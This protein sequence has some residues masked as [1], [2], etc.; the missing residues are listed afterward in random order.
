M[1]RRLAHVMLALLWLAAMLGGGRPV[2]AAAPPCGVSPI[3]AGCAV[4]PEDNIW[5]VPVDALPVHARSNAYGASIGADEPVHPDFGSGLWE[6][7]PIG[8]P[9][10]VVP[11]NQPKVEVSFYY[12]DESDLGPYPI[13]P[14]AP[15]EGGA[16]SDGDRHILVL[17]R[18]HCI[19]YEVYDAWPREDGSWECGSGAIY[20]LR[21]NA[22]RPDTW[23]SADAAGLP[24]LPGLVRYDEVAAG[25]ITHAIRVT[26]PRTQRAYVWP[27]RHYASSSTDPNLP[28]MGQRFRLKAGFDISGYSAE[29][30]VILRAMKKYGVILADNGAPWYISGAPDER[31]DND[32][33]HA[34]HNVS[35]SDFEAVDCSSLMLDPDSAQAACQASGERLYLPLA[36]G[37]NLVSLSLAP[38][39]TDPAAALSSIAGRYAAAYAYD[40]ANAADPWKLY[41]PGAPAYANDLTRL[42]ERMGWWV[43]AAAPVTLTLRGEAPISTTIALRAGWN[44]AGYPCQSARPVAEALAS[45]A[46]QVQAVYTY[47]PL[48]PADPWRL[49]D[50]D[51]PPASWTLTQM[52]PGKGYWIEVDRACQ[53]VVAGSS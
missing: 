31:W 11:G 38:A 1:M 22:L 24:I 50:P 18:D 2:G 29:V 8:I 34:L 46:A 20:D 44:L 15:I 45:I 40:A 48:H 36:Q 16:D 52:Q 4:F 25:E 51:A 27:A 5:N 9:F 12:P 3:L 6:G 19:L 13:P 47:D 10:C 30:Q 37:W 41:A 7:G 28:P 39:Q 53:W 14:D 32:A 43:K 33:L 17:D 21:S 35:G 42:D 26:A 23:T 49:Y